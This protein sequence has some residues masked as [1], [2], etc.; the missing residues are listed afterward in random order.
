MVMLAI[1]ICLSW[2]KTQ[3]RHRS[4]FMAGEDRGLAVNKILDEEKFGSKTK[5]RVG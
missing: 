1:Y 3:L 2:S 4:A 5:Q